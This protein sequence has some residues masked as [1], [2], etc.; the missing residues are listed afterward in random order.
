MLKQKLGGPLAI[1]RASDSSGGGNSGTA[2]GDLIEEQ[3]ELDSKAPQRT[4]RRRRA[5][6][7]ASLGSQFRGI[8]GTNEAAM[9]MPAM[10]RLA[11]GARPFPKRNRPQQCAARCSY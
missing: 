9:A 3:Q 7:E 8:G 1:N 4:Y 10:V 6:K 5:A 2:S 11:V